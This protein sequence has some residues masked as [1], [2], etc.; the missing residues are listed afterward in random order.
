MKNAIDVLKETRDNYM[1]LA[2][3]A[4]IAG[5][6]AEEKYYRD[7]AIECKAAIKKLKIK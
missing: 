6:K 1:Q 4:K 7:L 5:N 3:Y 2:R